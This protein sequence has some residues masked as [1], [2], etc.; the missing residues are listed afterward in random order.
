MSVGLPA[1][2]PGWM[3]WACLAGSF[4]VHRL[5]PTWLHKAQSSGDW[6]SLGIIS[7]P[8][9]L[10]YVYLFPGSVHQ[11]GL[12]TL[13][14]KS[15]YLVCKYLFLKQHSPLKKAR[16]PR[17]N[18]WIQIWGRESTRRAWNILCQKVRKCLLS[19]WELVRKHRTLFER[20][21]AGFIWD[22]SLKLNDHN[23]EL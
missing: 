8:R 11:K 7:W 17:T 23:K 10:M 20:A 13:W 5:R 15:I 19:T 1:V 21:L 16:A 14:Q 3:P 12:K 4:T 22:V 2:R 18:D 6:G 9:M